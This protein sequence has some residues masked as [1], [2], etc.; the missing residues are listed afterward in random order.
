MREVSELAQ[1]LWGLIE[2]YREAK[3]NDRSDLDRRF[4]IIL[5]D[6]E[7]I[8]AYHMRYLEDLL[9]SDETV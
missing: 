5:T 4:A 3:P 9:K 1:A 7:K 6:L 8:D 2:K